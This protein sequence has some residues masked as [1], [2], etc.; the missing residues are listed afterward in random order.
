MKYKKIFIAIIMTC[1]VAAIGMSFTYHPERNLKVLPKDISDKK[2]DSIMRSYTTALGVN[3]NF[4]HKAAADDPEKLDYASDEDPMKEN[5]R[6]MMR[7][8][9][10]MNT[11]YFYFDK[12][13]QPEFLNVVHCKTCHRGEPIP[14]DK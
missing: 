4:C 5:A 3:C 8:V 14:L 13:V 12:T 9:K 2:L 10:E 7:M 6:G 11:T 1:A